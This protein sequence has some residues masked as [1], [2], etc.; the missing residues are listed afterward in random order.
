MQANQKQPTGK[1]FQ[2][3]QKKPAMRRRK[4]VS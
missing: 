2:Y 1:L 4:T 3:F